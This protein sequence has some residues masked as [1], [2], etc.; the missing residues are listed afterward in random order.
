[1]AMYLHGEAYG[2]VLPRFRTMPAKRS[3]SRA[4]RE[5]RRSG[6]PCSPRVRLALRAMDIVNG[7]RKWGR[8]VNHSYMRVRNRFMA[9]K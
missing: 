4:V 9:M 6:R 1:M 5:F 3:W 2:S 7:G 8:G